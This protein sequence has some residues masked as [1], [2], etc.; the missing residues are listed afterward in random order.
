MDNQNYVLDEKRN[1]AFGDPNEAARWYE[2]ELTKNTEALLQLI[3][4]AE[5]LIRIA[6]PICL[7]DQK[8]IDRAS[9]II[10]QF[11]VR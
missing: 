11:G 7:N 8:W 4:S 9:G 6:T 5:V 3:E 2:Q 10:E 1:M